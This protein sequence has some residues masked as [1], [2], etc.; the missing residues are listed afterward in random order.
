MTPK[1]GH[2][3]AQD[4]FDLAIVGSGLTGGVLCIALAEILSKYDRSIV[5]CEKDPLFPTAKR[6]QDA[7]M[8]ALS[9]GGSGILADFG[10]WQDI[11]AQAYP[12]D[13]WEIS[14]MGKK[15]VV[16]ARDIG[17]PVLGYAVAFPVLHKAIAMQLARLRDKWKAFTIRSPFA[18]KSLAIAEPYSEL[19]DGE[20]TIQAQLIACAQGSQPYLAQLM[21]IHYDEYA[22]Q[23]KALVMTVRFKGGIGNRGY[24]FGDAAGNFV[25]LVP[26]SEDGEGPYTAILTSAIPSY[27]G[28][29]DHL[30]ADR[31]LSIDGDIQ[32]F[33]IQTYQAKE[34]VKAPLVLLGNAAHNAPP[35]GGQNYN[36]TLFT[37]HRLKILFAK[38]LKQSKGICA[39]YVLQE[40]IQQT[41]R[42]VYERVKAVHHLDRILQQPSNPMMKNLLWLAGSSSLRNS[43]F[44]RIVGSSWLE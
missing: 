19:S 14:F 13:S 22:E 31:I 1:R 35:L 16:R 41:E 39:R 10:L 36:L 25:A 6:K 38:S 18:V 15:L 32:T 44:R 42:E 28:V 8:L 26:Q 7:R 3:P 12:M 37:I 43:L 40:F 17:L 11:A 20:Y 4:V 5:L 21:H 9:Y 30:T 23:Q 27:E 24:W 33:P 34:R 2:N 29:L